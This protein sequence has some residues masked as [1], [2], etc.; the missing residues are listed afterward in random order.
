LRQAVDRLAGRLDALYAD[1]LSAFMPDPWSARDAYIRVVLGLQTADELIAETAGRRLSGDDALRTRLLLEVQFQ[2]H[3]MYASCGWYFED[4]DRIEPR[5]C[6]AYAASAILLAQRA[7]GVDLIS[8]FRDDLRQ[9]VSARIGLRGDQVLS[10]LL[11]RA[12]S[13]SN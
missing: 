5:N 12:T 4:F 2:R 3:K 7:T 8:S 6:V 10:H 13:I 9:V 11:R 1:N